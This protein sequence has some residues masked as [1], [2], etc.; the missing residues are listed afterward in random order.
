MTHR[1]IAFLAMFLSLFS[2][3]DK[4]LLLRNSLEREH[5]L[6]AKVTQSTIIISKFQITA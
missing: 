6:E 1:N 4:L 2:K 5:I 3:K